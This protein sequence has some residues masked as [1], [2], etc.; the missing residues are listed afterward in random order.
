MPVQDK[1]RSITIGEKTGS[2]QFDKN[3]YTE[4]S[5]SYEALIQPVSGNESFAKGKEGEDVT[6]RLYTHV[7]TPLSYS[8]SVTQDEKTYLVV[9][10][11]QVYG[12]SGMNHH[13][14]CLLKA[15]E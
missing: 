13:K 10:S 3:S 7:S 12:I 2:S 1:Y 6:H 9:Y 5:G 11:N 4:V 14:E 15:F 8:N